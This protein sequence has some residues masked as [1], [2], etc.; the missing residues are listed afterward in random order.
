MNKVGDISADVQ[1]KITSPSADES[2]LATAM[3]SWGPKLPLDEDEPRP[4]PRTGV[5]HLALEEY[6]AALAETTRTPLDMPAMMALAALSAAVNGKF[7][8][9]LA[10]GFIEPVNVFTVVA[11]A[12]GERKSAQRPLRAPLV[13]WETENRQ[14]CLAAYNAHTDT[15]KDL[16][17]TI[18]VL[19]ERKRK[20]EGDTDL[21]LELS[22]AY[23]MQAQMQLCAPPDGSLLAADATPEALAIKMHRAG[24]S[25]A[26]ITDEGGDFFQM[27]AGKYSDQGAALNIYLNGYD[28]DLFNRDRVTSKEPLR[29]E[30]PCLTVGVMTQPETLRSLMVGQS[31]ARGLVAR[32]LFSVPRSL[33][34]TRIGL[35]RDPL[36]PRL[37][38]EYGATLRRLLDVPRA[39]TG[40]HVLTLS[41]EARRLY[42]DAYNTIERRQDPKGDLYK[43]RDWA[44]KFSAKLGRLAALL[45]VASLLP[46]PQSTPTL[47][48]DRALISAATMEKALGLS[49]YF[50]EHYMRAFSAMTSSS[51]RDIALR[52][53]EW[54]R[55]DVPAMPDT[56]SSPRRVDGVYRFVVSEA[57][58]AVARNGA[59]EDALD[60]GLK[61]LIDK[62]YIRRVSV[63]RGK[64][65]PPE[66]YEIRPDL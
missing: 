12:S 52:I 35:T 2:G 66:V 9:Q 25:L 11:A 10:P 57:H 34:G 6:T 40:Y 60:P 4:W 53:V 43:H 16:A 55:R 3:D 17:Q 49:D 1:G 62:E 27:L 13:S 63:P 5:F 51:A 7:A 31:K 23:E 41:V 56:K 19:R 15:L 14:R 54:M 48:E 24:G 59:R 22:N 28:G 44:S 21:E 30:R 61:Y 47:F 26:L 38:S 29:I 18:H 46:R 37:Q 64:G 8:V 36:P 45:H 50:I 33:V 65:R 58:H 32:F 39:P 42:E 20:G